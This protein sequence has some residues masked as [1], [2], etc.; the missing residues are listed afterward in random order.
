MNGD[1]QTGSEGATSTMS[2]VRDALKRA[3]AMQ[4]PQGT[5]ATEEDSEQALASGDAPENTES[6]MEAG[7]PFDETP[8]PR[9]HPL[10]RVRW[11]R[12]LLR[13][14]G[15]KAS[16]PVPRCQGTTRMG[17]A[18]RGPAMANGF[19][20]LHGGS[21]QGVVAE[22]ARGLLDRVLAAR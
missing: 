19:C 11:L 4:T 3:N 6:I 12:K 20:R 15:V 7:A 9:Y 8:R 10:L 22:K 1:G 5:A 17:Q 18:C 2:R 13:L 14:V 16:A 21:R